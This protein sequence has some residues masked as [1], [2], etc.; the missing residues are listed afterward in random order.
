MTT[1]LL[2]NIVQAVLTNVANKQ[3]QKSIKRKE[4][5]SIKIGNKRN[6]TLIV[7]GFLIVLKYREPQINY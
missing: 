5:E 2:F 7:D 3:K 1:Q 4:V 6:L